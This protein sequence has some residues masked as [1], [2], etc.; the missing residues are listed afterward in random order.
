MTAPM[1]IIQKQ[2]VFKKLTKYILIAV[3]M[4]AIKADCTEI[5][6]L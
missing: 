4:L 6:Q 5:T 2:G 1:F 3:T